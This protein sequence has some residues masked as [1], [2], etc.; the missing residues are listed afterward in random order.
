MC[1]AKLAA[2]TIDG[3]GDDPLNSCDFANG[4]GLAV[5]GIVGSGNINLDGAGNLAST[6]DDGQ[7]SGDPNLCG[8]G[9]KPGIQLDS[10]SCVTNSIG[11]GV[12]DG[13]LT[14]VTADT[15]GNA[16]QN[17]VCPPNPNHIATG[18]PCIITVAEFDSTALTADD[19]VGF[20][21][22]QMKPP[23]P[24][25]SENVVNTIVSVPPTCNGG[26]CPVGASG[27]FGPIAP[28]TDVKITGR[29]FPC[30]V[31]QPDDPSVNG[32]QNSCLVAHTAK[33]LLVKRI[34]TQLLV[35]CTY[36]GN[37]CI[38]SQT[39]GTDGR[40]TITFDMPDTLPGSGFADS[41]RFVPHAAPDCV[42]NQGPSTTDPNFPNTCESNR[43]NASGIRLYK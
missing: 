34:T 20:H 3:G 36:L 25:S 13:G 21:V 2:P 24:V 18:W 15:C 29:R 12:F 38:Q 22:I 26:A 9:T 23:I 42:F 27:S 10:P 33:T 6:A 32:G 37:P 28:G 17:A 35:P 39:A 5:I 8:P 16:N 43:L 40:Y 4:R 31:V 14:A 41:F 19:H 30:R 11:G 1:N 7:C